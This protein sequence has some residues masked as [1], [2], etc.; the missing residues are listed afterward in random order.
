VI[1][2]KSVFAS[3]ASN[4]TPMIVFMVFAALG[5]AAATWLWNRERS[6]ANLALVALT[7]GSLLPALWQVKF[8]PYAS[9]LAAFAL[10]L[11]IAS[12]R[13]IGSLSALSVRLLGAMAVNQS[14]L[15]LLAGAVLLLGGASRDLVEGKGAPETDACRST[16]AIAAL[17]RLPEGR[18]VSQIDIGPFIAA[19]T[20]HHVF[21]AP[22]HRLDAA[23]V[24]THAIFRSQPEES[25][26][27]LANTGAGYLV[28][29]VA[30]WRDG[31]QTIVEEGLEKGSLHERLAAG[32]QFP[33]LKE[34]S[35]ASPVQSLRVW[36]IVP[37]SG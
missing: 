12:A 2:T 22:Y 16:P 27:R 34:I 30:P 25:R 8:I 7:V 11:A 17:A 23:I 3:L 15:A 4:P 21:S 28:A 5:I 14:S 29:C 26:R 35:G 9:W 31:R 24:E 37:S 36:R 13:P 1:E 33:F 20:P 6:A 18:I 19:L 10:T 32:E